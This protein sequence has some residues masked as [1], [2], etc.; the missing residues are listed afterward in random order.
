MSRYQWIEEV[1]KY[2]MPELTYDNNGNILTLQRNSIV[3]TTLGN[4]DN[5]TYTYKGNHLLGVND[6][7]NN[8]EGFNDN[9]FTDVVIPEQENTHE[10]SYD[11]N[12]NMTQDFNKG[13]EFI[14]YNYLNKPYYI[15]FNRSNYITYIYDAAGTKLKKTVHYNGTETSTDYVGDFVYHENTLSF[16]A[17]EAGRITPQA[18]GSFRN[19]YIIADHLGNTRTLFTDANSDG[20]PEI[21]QENHYDPFCMAIGNLSYETPDG[22]NKYKY[23]G[24]E[25]QDDLGLNWYDYGA[26]MYDA[27]IGRWHVVDPMANLRNWVSSYTY[28]QNNPMNRIDP[29]GA[30]DTKYEDEEGNELLNTED[31]SSAVVTVT[32]DK[33][34]G[35][36]A[37]V[38]GTTEEQQNDP[39]WNK[40]MKKYILGFELSDKQEGILNQ[41]NSDWSRRNAIEFW[42]DPSVWNTIKM[43]GSEYLSQWSNP[44]LVVAGLSAGVATFKSIGPI[45]SSP[46]N[47]PTKSAVPGTNI[48]RTLYPG[49]IVNRYGKLQGKWAA[50]VGTSFESR[51]IPEYLKGQGPINLQVVKEIKV[52]Q[53]L[54]MPGQHSYQSGYGVQFEFPTSFDKLIPEFLKIVE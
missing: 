10:Y 8:T 32:D 18:D 11:N 26:R 27:A 20:K 52:Q 46:L 43:A 14:K 54:S 47:Y 9:G 4:M 6:A 19:E 23:N 38:K 48:N 3:N 30:L 16:A 22:N 24:K 35:F 49:E 41:L 45:K 1:N 25:L 7:S 50:P 40:T 53:S 33:R 17:S 12:G 29:D 13:V 51:S 2:S 5:L 34:K 31:G 28:C 44:E 37:A 39:S 42:K 36:D 15:S 21:L